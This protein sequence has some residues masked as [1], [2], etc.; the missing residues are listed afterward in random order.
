M[1]KKGSKDLC[2]KFCAWLWRWFKINGIKGCYYHHFMHASS[3]AKIAKNIYK[4]NLV[5]SEKFQKVILGALFTSIYAKVVV[6]HTWL[7][8]S[9]SITFIGFNRSCRL[10]WEKLSIYFFIDFQSSSLNNNFSSHQ[11]KAIICWLM[12]MHFAREIPC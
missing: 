5:S 4:T 2:N 10:Q 9:M 6:L 11:A 8:N 3:W 1:S 12:D 7:F